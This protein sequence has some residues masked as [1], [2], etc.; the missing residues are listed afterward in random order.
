MAT[1][2][3]WYLRTAMLYLIAGFT[4][5]M[6][7]L[8][9]KGIA[10]HPALWRLLPAHIEFLLFGWTLQ[11]VFGTA[12][13][14]LPRFR[15]RRGNV[16]LAWLAY[17]LLNIGIWLT[18]LGYWLAGQWGLI[19]GGRIAEASAAAA[20]ALHAWPRVKPPGA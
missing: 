8:V 10:L 2:S 15:T 17:F 19:A 12:F 1:L 20:F 3:V 6:L 18:V 4:V 9:N 11:L 5:G 7:L 14:I 16:R 13:W